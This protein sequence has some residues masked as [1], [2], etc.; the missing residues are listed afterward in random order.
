MTLLRAWGVGNAVDVDLVR[1][2]LRKF[3]K[4]HR[5]AFEEVSRRQAQFLEIGAMAFVVEHYRKKKYAI[6]AM[7]LSGGRIFHVKL[8]SRGNPANYSWFRCRRGLAEFD[9][10]LNLPVLSSYGDGGV[11]VVDVG[12]VHAGL[13]LT[14][15]DGEPLALRNRDL[16]TFAEVKNFKIYPMLL[17]HFV[18]IV[19]EI[20]PAFLGRRRP[21]GFA[22]ANHFSPTLFT[23]GS[24]TRN[25]T[26]ILGGFAIRKYRV[27]VVP[28]FDLKIAALSA[29]AS[30]PSPLKP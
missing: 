5:G 8:G 27:N 2:E 7:G 30:T 14:R 10:Y 11:Y 28:T 22:K 21:N 16:I 25:S 4:H 26:L 24:I 18:G 23:V 13:V 1:R 19:H 3:V 17:A 20:Q 6:E 12:V 9:V 15:K 29:D